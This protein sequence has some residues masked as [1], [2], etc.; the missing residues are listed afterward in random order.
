MYVVHAVHCHR[1]GCHWYL[2]AQLQQVYLAS[3]P[4]E[5]DAVLA[6]RSRLKTNT[7]LRAAARQ[8]GVPIYAVKSSSSSNLVRA[9]RTLLGLEPSAGSV[10]GS[11]GGS[12]DDDDAVSGGSSPA[13]TVDDADSVATASSSSRTGGIARALQEEEE[14]LDEARLAAEQIVIPL[15]QP[16]DLLPRSELVRKAQSALCGRLGLLSEVVGEGGDSRVRILPTQQPRTLP[17][18]AADTERSE[19]A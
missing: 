14:G 2:T 8:A 7:D 19:D 3:R 15:Q 11:R 4:S 17:G 9:F 10:F 18:A 13:D 12:M 16:V 5:A 6:V 1:A